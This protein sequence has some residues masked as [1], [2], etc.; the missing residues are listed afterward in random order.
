MKQQ[1]KHLITTTITLLLL[2]SALSEVQPGRGLFNATLFK[3]DGY[4]EDM[5]MAFDLSKSQHPVTF[6]STEGQLIGAG[7]PTQIKTYGTYGVTQLDLV[8]PISEVLSA[9]V[10]DKSKVVFQFF[11][12]NGKYMLKSI[13]QDFTKFGVDSSCTSFVPNHDRGYIYVG[14]HHR[15]T[16]SNPGAIHIHTYDLAS[17]TVIATETVEEN[18]EFKIFNRLE[19]F[20]TNAPQGGEGDEFYLIAYDQGRSIQKERRGGNYVRV[21]RNVASRNLRYYLLSEIHV[22]GQDLTISYDLFSYGTNVLLTG[23]NQQTQGLI[24]IS[25]CR[26]VNEDNKVICGQTKAT[27]VKE[28]VITF[29]EGRY[30]ELNAQTQT[31]KVNNLHGDFSSSGWNTDTVH[32]AEKLSLLDEEGIWFRTVT[33]NEHGAV[34]NYDINGAH[35]EYAITMAS[36]HSGWSGVLKSTTGF[37]WEK[38][39]IAG[40]L[41]DEKVYSYRLTYDVITIPAFTLQDGQNE[42]KITATDADNSATVSGNITVIEDIHDLLAFREVEPVNLT[43]GD[44]HNV[45]RHLVESGNGLTWEVKSDDEKIAKVFSLSNHEVT[46]NFEGGT[47]PTGNFFFAGD[48]VVVEAVAP[49]YKKLVYSTCIQPDLKDINCTIHGN[50]EINHRTVVENRIIYLNRST[51]IMYSNSFETS[52]SQIYIMTDKEAYT[53][54]FKERIIDIN[55][56]PGDGSKPNHVVIAFEGRVEVWHVN[57]NDIQEWNLMHS[58][59]KDYYG[60]DNFCPAGL[61]KDPLTKMNWDIFSHCL[62]HSHFTSYAS[63]FR[64]SL[65]S[66]HHVDHHVPLSNLD[67]PSDICSFGFEYLVTTDIRAYGIDLFD[68]WNYWSI[69]INQFDISRSDFEIDCIETRNAAIMWGPSQDD[70]SNLRVWSIRGDSGFRQDRR[71]PVTWE[72]KAEKIHNFEFLHS[73]ISVAIQGEQTTFVQSWVDPIIVVEAMDV[74]AESKTEI[75]ITMHNGLK[76]AHVAIPVTVNPKQEGEKKERKRFLVK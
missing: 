67:T 45:G 49:M 56:A 41:N 53:K 75:E 52:D 16:E 11:D 39:V 65:G 47:A 66:E 24:T 17:Q 22:V 70:P 30:V 72:V 26:L 73:V 20:I 34:I 36:F 46:I 69:P 58:F 59:D 43:S 44:F 21:F 38:N 68:D 63:I 31:L 27:T 55:G 35:T 37:V 48:M 12:H 51:S 4:S 64:L 33:V 7:H 10:Y 42:V 28:G 60:V 32:L 3:E 74:T 23:R 54:N 62:T 14:C 1:T 8:V 61:R 50:L 19:M 40:N 29:R 6:T 13:F 5:R 9:F 25:L 2:S 71:Y 18:D 15:E 76:T 57:P